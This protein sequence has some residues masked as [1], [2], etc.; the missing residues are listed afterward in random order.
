MYIKKVVDMKMFRF[1]Q[2]SQNM[3]G[4]TLGE[5]AKEWR[6]CLE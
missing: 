6:H 1:S 4:I 5:K 2:I 3:A